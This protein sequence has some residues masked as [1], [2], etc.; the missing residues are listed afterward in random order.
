MFQ[1]QDLRFVT[2][3]LKVEPK[4]RHREKNSWWDSLWFIDGNSL[5][6]CRISPN[7]SGI[8]DSGRSVEVVMPRV[9]SSFASMT[10]GKKF[11]DSV[12]RCSVLEPRSGDTA[13]TFDDQAWNTL[14]RYLDSLWME[15]SLL[16]KGK[17]FRMPV[18]AFSFAGTFV[19][20]MYDSLI[21]VV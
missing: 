2:V 16:G 8:L 19:Q 12:I 5:S 4:K 13:D 1:A 6:L 21:E 10:E 9:A 7:R 3:R 11:D 15:L 17:D 20:L 14:I 18:L